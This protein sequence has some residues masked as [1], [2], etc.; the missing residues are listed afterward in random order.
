MRPP[1]ILF[2]YFSYPRQSALIR[3]CPLLP[4]L[5]FVVSTS[6]F[7]QRGGKAEPNRIEFPSGAA[8]TTVNGTVRNDQQVEYVFAAKKGQHVIIHVTST[9]KQ[10]CAFELRGP[11]N[12][13]IASEQLYYS[14]TLPATGD[15]LL[16]VSRPGEPGGRSTYKLKVEVR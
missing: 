15:Y 4:I 11:E 10:S 16:F 7:A 8:S 9:P 5:L 1:Q 2:Q 14:A 6:A 3:G 13:V 12:D